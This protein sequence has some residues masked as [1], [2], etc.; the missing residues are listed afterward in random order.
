MGCKCFMKDNLI[1]VIVPVYNVGKYLCECIDSILLQSY[2]NFELILVDDGSSD[3]CS[4]ICDEYAKKDNRITVIRQ[5]NQGVS[6]ARNTGIKVSHGD[7]IMFVDGD[8]WLEKDMLE[9]LLSGDLSCDVIACKVDNNHR[10]F[11][12]SVMKCKVYDLCYNKE[13]L[14]EILSLK[15]DELMCPVAKI[16]KSKCIKENQIYFHKYAKAAEDQM[17]NL[18]VY[19]VIK[20]IQILKLSKYHYRLNANSATMSFCEDFDRNKYFVKYL[21]HMIDKYKFMGSIIYRQLLFSV[22]LIFDNRRKISYKKKKA[23][24]NIHLIKYPYCEVLKRVSIFNVGFKHWIDFLFFK[25]RFYFGIYI[26]Y[27]VRKALLKVKHKIKN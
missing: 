13:D 25:C 21:L 20:K 23:L 2:K 10:L 18:D 17:F 26:I 24:L 15:R 1:S 12:S 27:Y 19:Q 7:W 5:D 22:Y 4:E 8:D 3:N 16:Y 11:S 6:S 14:F 9:Y